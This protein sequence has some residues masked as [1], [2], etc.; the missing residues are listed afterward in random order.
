MKIEK[1]V[2]IEDWLL[3]N[4][5]DKQEDWK[6]LFCTCGLNIHRKFSEAQEL[7]NEYLKV[8]HESMD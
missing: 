4:Q 2:R 3:I 8:N 1:C 6:F 5:S 7:Y